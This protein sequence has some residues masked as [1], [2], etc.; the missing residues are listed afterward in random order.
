MKKTSTSLDI[1]E[2][3]I[4]ITMKY[5][6][7]WVVSKRQKVAKAGKDVETREPYI[8]LVGWWISTTTHHREQYGVFSKHWK[9]DY[10]MILPP[11]FCVHVSVCVYLCV[12]VYVCVSIF[13][14]K[15]YGHVKEIHTLPCLLWPYSQ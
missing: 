6:V 15:I 7:I 2:T 11:H 5:L 8:L 12:C 1:R 3:Q 13:S 10:L 14:E 9:Q 4:K